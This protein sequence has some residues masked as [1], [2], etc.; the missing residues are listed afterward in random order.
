MQSEKDCSKPEK[1]WFFP[2]QSD[3]ELVFHVYFRVINVNELGED[4]E[5]SEG[6]G[7]SVCCYD[8]DRKR[9]VLRKPGCVILIMPFYT[10]MFCHGLLVGE[11]YLL[12]LSG[13][14]FSPLGHMVSVKCPNDT[15]W[16]MWQLTQVNWAFLG[17]FACNEVLWGSR[18]TVVRGCPAVPDR[19]EACRSLRPG[20]WM[21]TV[22]K[23]SCCKLS[24]LE[25][26]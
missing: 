16:G 26:V 24:V 13:D 21:G 11:D 20:P 18:G 5:L 4:I 22:R 10:R 6:G 25:S 9:V 7:G 14:S 12:L 17:S 15:A 2:W 23:Q 1:D 8:V 3:F 19:F